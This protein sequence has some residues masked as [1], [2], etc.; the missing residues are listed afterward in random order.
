M[1]AEDIV[2]RS[3]MQTFGA[4]STDTLCSP[5]VDGRTCVGSLL[6]EAAEISSFLSK[7]D[8]ATLTRAAKP[9]PWWFITMLRDM[10]GRSPVHGPW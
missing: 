8:N 4:L 9:F 2:H 1:R 7:T 3:Y 10:K 6:S 5:D